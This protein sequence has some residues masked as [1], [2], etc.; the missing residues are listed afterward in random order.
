METISL[1]IYRTL[2]EEIISG[3][4]PPGA[5]L[6]EIALAERFKVSRTPIRQALRE[7]AARGMIELKPRK[8]GIVTSIGVDDLA[9]MLEAMCEL[10]A[11][12]CRICAERMSAVQKKQLELVHLQSQECVANGDDAGYLLLNKKFHNLICAGAHNRSLSETIDNLR[13]RLALF[14]AAQTGVDK[15]LTVSHEEHE[16]II[17]AILASDP[18]KAYLAMRNHT[19]R[20][21]IHVLETIKEHQ[22]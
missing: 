2:T 5:A 9:D 19:T 11:L 21:S 15:R 8:G 17:A 14:R 10:E 4:L 16:A 20:L 12:C 13:D 7:L 6:E 3:A 1:R 18:E 22:A